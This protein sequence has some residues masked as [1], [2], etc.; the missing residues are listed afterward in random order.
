MKKILISSCLL[1]AN[2]KYS[3]GNNFSQNLIDLL[4]KYEIQLIPICPEVSG[5][6]SIPR[7]PAE[8][9]G[10]DIKNNQGKSVMKEFSCGAEKALKLAQENKV[11]LAILKERSP[12]C[13][14]NYIYDGTFSGTLIR[15]VG[16]TA[17]ILRKNN[18]SV[19]SEENLLE[20]ERVLKAD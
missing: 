6:L 18:I 16:L 2:V 15:G 14:S 12:S 13:G 19:F 5:G 3:G 9:S 1:G 8:I 4:S 10:D 20:I 11:A 7:I 17:K